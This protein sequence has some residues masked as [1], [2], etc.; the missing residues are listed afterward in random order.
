M[1]KFKDYITKI[2]AKADSKQMYEL[3][4]ILDDHFDEMEMVHPESYWEVMNEL[5]MV[6]NGPY[7]DEECA[8]YAVSEM[9]NEDGTTGGH[10]TYDDTTGVAQQ[11]G[12]TFDKFNAWDWFYT[13]NMVYSDFSTIIGSSVPS[14]IQFAKTWLMDKDAKD[15][16]A[17]LYW[18]AVAK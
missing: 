17:Y 16:K 7:F 8:K 6:V 9:V 15:G 3:T 13:L 10:W 5:H 11:N 18:Q 1:S 14:Y 2:T 12:I 4:D